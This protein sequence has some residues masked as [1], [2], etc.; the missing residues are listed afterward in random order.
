M[1]IGG[2]DV[3]DYPPSILSSGLIAT[4]MIEGKVS[5]CHATLR[6]VNQASL[7]DLIMAFL[8]DR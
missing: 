3:K 4:G 6:K 2:P 5:R 1:V 7:V 8:L